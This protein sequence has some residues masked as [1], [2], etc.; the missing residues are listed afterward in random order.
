[1]TLVGPGEGVNRFD[2]VVVSQRFQGD[3][4]DLEL[5]LP[6]GGPALRCKA[7]VGA[8]PANH[9]AR[10]EIRPEHIEILTGEER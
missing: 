1:V 2:C 7:R 10:I 5:R 9:T 8:L 3:L 6:N 4:R